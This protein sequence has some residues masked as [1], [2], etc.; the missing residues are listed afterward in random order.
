MK[1]SL[2]SSEHT[3]EKERVPSFVQRMARAA[4]AGFVAAGT[5]RLSR[6][7]Y[8]TG[9]TSR[10]SAIM[11]TGE[12]VEVEVEK[13]TYCSPANQIRLRSEGRHQW[14]TSRVRLACSY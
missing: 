11:G 6:A 14:Q 12:G 10:G 5:W 13:D 8:N 2:H 9:Q 3:P 4:F 1:R 7:E